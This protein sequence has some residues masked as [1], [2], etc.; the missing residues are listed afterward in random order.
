M[1]S[2]KSKAGKS[3]ATFCANMNLNKHDHFLKEKLNQ[4]KGPDFDL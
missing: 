2:T 1:C 3:Q 4:G